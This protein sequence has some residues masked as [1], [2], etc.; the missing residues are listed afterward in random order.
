MVRIPYGRLEFRLADSC[1]NPYL[2][3]VAGLD[4]IERKLNPGEPHNFNHYTKS[5][6][7]L[8]ELGIKILPQN[9]NEAMQALEA[10]TLFSK[11]L[12]EAFV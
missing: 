8:K 6:A 9:L 7:Q 3:I 10:D 2:V 4:G 1:C 11:S 12:G 5:D